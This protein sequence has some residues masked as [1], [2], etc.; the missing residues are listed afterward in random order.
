MISKN[1]ALNILKNDKFNNINV[2][3]FIENYPINYIEK[4]CDSLVIKG[5]SDRPWVYIVSKS[6]N[7]LKFIK[8]SLND[9]D[10]NFAIIEN[11][12]IRVLTSGKKIKWILSA[13]RL[14]LPQEIILPAPLYTIS[15]LKDAD[16]SFIYESSD[17]KDFLS[18]EYV[19]ERVTNGI[20]SC[21]RIDNTPIA[22][23]MTQDD[24]AIGFLHVLPR[25]R[26]KGYGREIVLDL[27]QKVRKQ[28]RLPFV[29]IEENN[30]KS[31]NLSLSLGFKKDKIVNWFEIE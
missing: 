7:E 18:I 5:I 10:K 3:N 12:M 31:M 26:R 11:W 16:C 6:E 22:W 27:I 19:K 29:H 1:E 2:T 15:A 25:Y 28:G 8:K 4:I 13:Y 9:K 20:S 17:Y 21:I 24:G 14:F 30:E 23:G